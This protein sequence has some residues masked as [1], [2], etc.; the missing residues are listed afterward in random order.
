MEGGIAVAVGSVGDGQLYLFGPEVL[1]RAQ[2]H[3]TF[4]FF[5]NGIYLAGASEAQLGEVATGG[6]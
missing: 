1:F 3:G 5:F 2:P 6:Q 4:K